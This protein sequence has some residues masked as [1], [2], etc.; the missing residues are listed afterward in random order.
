ME[1][2]GIWTGELYG[3]YGWENSGVYVLE[4]GFMLGGNNRH[5]STGHYDVSGTKFSAKVDVH[6]Y[7]PARAIFGE[8][9]EQFEIELTGEI[10]DGVIEAEISR[11]DRPQF[12]VQYRLTRRMDLPS[13]L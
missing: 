9:K 1:L 10:G 3:P 5:Y 4:N 13:A 8:R 11:S 7:G 12:D 2:E 6:Y